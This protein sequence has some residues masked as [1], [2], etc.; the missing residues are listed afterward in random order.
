MNKITIDNFQAHDHTEMLLHPTGVSIIKG[1]SNSGKSSIIRALR[2]VIEN[3]PRGFGFRSNFK[4]LKSGNLTSVQIDLDNIS[5]IRERNKL[6]GDKAVNCYRILKDGQQVFFGEALNTDVPNEVKEALNMDSLNIHGQHDKFFMLQETAGERGRMLNDFCDM[7]VIDRTLSKIDSK[8][9]K[10]ANDIKQT[11]SDISKL[12]DKISTLPDYEPY[13]PIIQN[14]E[15]DIQRLQRL[16]SRFSELKSLKEKHEILLQEITNLSVW[17]L[18]QD[19]IAAILPDITKLREL[20]NFR[21]DINYQKE[22]KI[23]LQTE[24]DETEGWSEV[25][26]G[27]QFILLDVQTLTAKINLRNGLK[28]LKNTYV[29]HSSA[30]CDLDKK[31]QKAREEFQ[32]LLEESGTCPLCGATTCH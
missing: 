21:F 28:T 19:R 15:N 10:T 14:L 5:V 32:K 11:E 24:V 8:F 6:T 25:L 7:S 16:N 4:E 31:E 3:R 26:K 20:K 2:W 23:I 18:I 13:L 30:I 17:I 12:A 9:R 22:N 27:C 1:T 29:A